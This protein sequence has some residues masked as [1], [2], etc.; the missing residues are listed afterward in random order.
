MYLEP[1]ISFTPSRISLFTK[2]LEDSGKPFRRPKVNVVIP[3]VNVARPE[4]SK[5]AAR[6]IKDKINWL[7]QLAKNKRV[8]YPNGTVSTNFK[9]ALITLTLPAKQVHSDKEIKAK[10]LNQFLTEMRQQYGMKHYVWKAELQGNDNIHFH[11]TTN[12]FV[13][14]AKVRNIWNRIIS[15]LGYVSAY[16]DKMRALSFS[17]YASLRRSQGTKSMSEIRKGWAA[18]HVNEWCNPN[19][20][21]V[22]TVFKV[23]N[24]ASYL[25]K[26][27]SK[28]ISK[29]RE[30]DKKNDRAANFGG[31]IWYCSQS[32]SKLKSYVTLQSNRAMSFC[33]DII[34]C[35]G[36][37]FLEFD[38]CKCFYFDPSKLPPDIKLRFNALMAAYI[39]SAQCAK[40]IIKPK[41]N[42]RFKITD[43]GQKPRH[44]ILPP[45]AQ[46]K[47]AF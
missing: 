31:N 12:S 9:L 25:A 44:E 18:G 29:S 40:N 39:K 43:H 7:V 17:D 5:K 46:L 36:T 27:L 2:V 6:N 1:S 3:K 24:L 38:Y 19:S 15:K 13:N 33:S 45:F 42:K 32:L 8:I 23:N 10:C 37:R 11:I 28:S 41:S 22:K 26:Y 14:H 34:S 35:V 16:A 30:G 4:M 21:D 47:I 20:T